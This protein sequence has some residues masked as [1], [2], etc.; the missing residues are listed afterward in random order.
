MRNVL[1]EFDFWGDGLWYFFNGF[2]ILENFDFLDI[3][4][5]FKIRQD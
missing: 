3:L 2:L 5:N 1:S 4:F